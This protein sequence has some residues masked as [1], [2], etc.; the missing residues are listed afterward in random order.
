MAQAIFN[1]LA[2]DA[3]L[4]YRAE[5]AGVAALEGAEAAPRVAETL[6]EIGV[7]ADPHHVARQATEEV[8]AG[9]ELILTMTPQQA[10]DLRRALGDRAGAIHPLVGYVGGIPDAG[11]TDPYGQSSTAYRAVA[12]QLLE[13]LELL[14]S[15]FQGEARSHQESFPGANEAAGGHG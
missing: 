6:A 12:R 13:C 15:R 2:E 4:P 5:S 10:M 14:V 11:V 1:A 3:N 7:P 9:A 8:A